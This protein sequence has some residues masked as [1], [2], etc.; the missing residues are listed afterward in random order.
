MNG[1]RKKHQYILALGSLMV[2]STLILRHYHW[3]SDDLQG[4][5]TGLGVGLMIASL[6]VKRKQLRTASNCS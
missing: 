6:I 2:A 1:K 4:F 5:I 3:A